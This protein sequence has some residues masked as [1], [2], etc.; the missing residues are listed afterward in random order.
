MIAINKDYQEEKCPMLFFN[1][2]KSGNNRVLGDCTAC[3]EKQ[4]C[5]MEHDCGYIQY[6]EEVIDRIAT[7]YVTLK[8]EK[9]RKAE[10]IVGCVLFSI[11]VLLIVAATLNFLIEF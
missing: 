6:K 5:I 7:E 2:I 3:G 8:Y 9:K 11:V 1:N 10:E 4:V